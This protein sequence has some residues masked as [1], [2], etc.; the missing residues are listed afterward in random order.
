[1]VRSIRLQKFVIRLVS[2][3]IISLGFAQVSNAGMIGTQQLVDDNARISTIA[4]VEALLVR[5]DV[6]QQL[7]YF[8]VDQAFVQARVKN[9]TQ[10]ELA[11][12]EGRLDQ[13]IAGGTDIISVIGVVFLVLMILELLGVTDVFKSF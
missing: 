6:A 4:R 11:E 12:L 2:F 3:S 9:M 8:G 7:Q 10:T 13:H 1:M 5:Q